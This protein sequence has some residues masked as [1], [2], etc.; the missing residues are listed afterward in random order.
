M[1]A[2]KA[3]T[4]SSKKR[5]R[6][7]AGSL[8]TIARKHKRLSSLSSKSFLVL[9]LPCV[10]KRKKLA[11][12]KSESKSIQNSP[13]SKLNQKFGYH[14]KSFT[15][16]FKRPYTLIAFEEFLD[17]KLSQGKFQVPGLDE[18]ESPTVKQ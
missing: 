13:A 2:N 12:S 4:I 17:S 7:A 1:K 5:S 9:Y 6:V 16:R 8:L 14:K 10:R 11:E 3:N 18:D 15:V